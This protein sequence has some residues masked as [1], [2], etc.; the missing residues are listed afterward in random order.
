VNLLPTRWRNDLINYLRANAGS[1]IM[2]TVHNRLSLAPWA[3]FGVLCAYAAVAIGAALLLIDVRDACAQAAC[4]W[5]PRTRGTV[6][7]ERDVRSTR[8]RRVPGVTLLMAALTGT[9]RP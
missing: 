1:Q 9:R 3:G 8:T 4:R 2:T 7:R 6:V 5:A